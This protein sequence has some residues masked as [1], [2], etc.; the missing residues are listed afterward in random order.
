MVHFIQTPRR[1]YHRFVVVVYSVNLLVCHLIQLY[2]YLRH[3]ARSFPLGT[4]N[5]RFLLFF[6]NHEHI[7]IVHRFLGSQ[8]SPWNSFAP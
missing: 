1:V 5:H 3:S 7:L 8:C 6:P 2:S 4:G